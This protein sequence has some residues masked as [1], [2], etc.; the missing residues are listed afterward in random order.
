MMT[1]IKH[2]VLSKRIDKLINHNLYSKHIDNLYWYDL[3]IKYAVSFLGFLKVFFWRCFHILKFKQSFVDKYQDES[4]KNYGV[5]NIYFSAIEKKPLTLSN[6]TIWNCKSISSC[7]WP[8]K[9]QWSELLEKNVEAIKDE[10]FKSK[11]NSTI[12]PG[13]KLLTDKGLWSSITLIGAKGVD[14]NNSKSFPKTIELLSKMP[15]CR[16]FGF[17]AFSK[18]SPKTHIKA[19]TG[20]TNLRL[21]YHLGIQVPEPELV[22]IRVGEEKKSWLQNK[23]IIFDD[24]FEHEVQHNGN[25][26]RVVLIVDLWHPQ[27]TNVEKDILSAP[28]F[29]NFGK[30]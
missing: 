19:H 25:Q 11:V 24:S 4:P 3:N 13:N 6:P 16:N 17:V 8:E 5:K 2:W 23:C 12:H 30:S 27:L 20:S 14:L 29:K 26:D 21:R 15:V 10:F 28:E 7:P 9:D 22:K 1:L 18:L